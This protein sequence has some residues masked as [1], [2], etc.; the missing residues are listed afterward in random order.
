MPFLTLQVIKSYF[1]GVTK[2]MQDWG[3]KKISVYKY[4]AIFIVLFFSPS[5][6]YKAP[7]M[8]MKGATKEVSILTSRKY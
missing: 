4:L 8:G 5:S 2:G 6:S 7:E 1:L 3:G